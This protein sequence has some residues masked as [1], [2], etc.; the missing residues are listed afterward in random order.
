ME[1]M[2]HKNKTKPMVTECYINLKVYLV[3]KLH[4]LKVPYSIIS[5]MKHKLVIQKVMQK[6][7]EEDK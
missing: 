7:G 3:Q 1:N 6:K 4:G 5:S 2:K